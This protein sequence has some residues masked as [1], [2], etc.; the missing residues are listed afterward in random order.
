MFRCVTAA[1][2][3]EPS[4]LL[5]AIS[6]SEVASGEIRSPPSPLVSPLSTSIGPTARCTGGWLEGVA[7][8]SGS[9]MA[10][11]SCINRD[12]TNLTVTVGSSDGGEKER[13]ELAR[14]N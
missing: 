1:H 10:G 9:E 6:V 8:G 3:R 4:P 5:H 7:V 14:Q 11:K 2:A 13:S 12:L